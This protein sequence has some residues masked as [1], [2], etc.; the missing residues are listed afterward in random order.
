MCVHRNS[1]IA[2]GSGHEAIPVCRSLEGI[3]E[4]DEGVALLRGAVGVSDVTVRVVPV[5]SDNWKDA[6]IEPCRSAKQSVNQQK[7]DTS[8]NSTRSMEQ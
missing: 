4:Q 5:L 1:L 8:I 6:R 7:M 2:G 3:V